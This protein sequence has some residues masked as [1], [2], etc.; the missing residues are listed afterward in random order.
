M[1]EDKK[2]NNINKATFFMMLINTF[3]LCYAFVLCL[4][5]E[6]FNRLFNGSYLTDR[7]IMALLFFGLSFLNLVFG[8]FS[9]KFEGED[10]ISLIVK[11]KRLEEQQ[12]IR[13]LES[14]N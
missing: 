12:R 9:R 11:R 14:K 3:A 1:S 2:K 4:D 7:T 6:A 10:I 8:I 5:Y 13:D